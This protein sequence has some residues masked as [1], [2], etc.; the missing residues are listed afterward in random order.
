MAIVNRDTI[1]TWFE[2]GD[3]PTQQQ[4]AD[5][6]DS[7]WHKLEGIPISAITGLSTVLNSLQPNP[8]ITGVVESTGT[9]LLPAGKLIEAIVIYG[10]SDGGEVLLGTTAGGDEWG[11]LPIDEADESYSQLLY[12]RLATARTIFFTSTINFTYAIY[13]R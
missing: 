3:Y 2:T 10:Q 1:K 4:F 5:A 9:V 6:W 11:S 8:P 12:K 7:Y 13:T